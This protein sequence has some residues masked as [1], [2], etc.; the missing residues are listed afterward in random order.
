MCVFSCLFPP[1]TGFWGSLLNP[2]PILDP[3]APGACRCWCVWP[4]ASPAQ[5]GGCLAPG[6]TKKPSVR[7][8][9]SRLYQHLHSLE[10]DTSAESSRFG[11]TMQ[12]TIWINLSDW[13][14]WRSCATNKQN[15]TPHQFENLFLCRNANEH[16]AIS[17]SYCI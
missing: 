10:F 8:K 15:R 16:A 3:P 17:V 9:S 5:I 1:P 2:W 4:R 13:I 12:N 14:I 11:K 7:A 6:A